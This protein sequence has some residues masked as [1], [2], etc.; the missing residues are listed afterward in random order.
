MT[1]RRV[2][3][4]DEDPKR[5]V[6]DARR[7]GELMHVYVH[8]SR[9]PAL[10]SNALMVDALA[11]MEAMEYDPDIDFVVV[12]GNMAMIAMLIANLMARDGTINM[13]LFDS[14]QEEYV[15]KTVQ[16]AVGMPTPQNGTGELPKHD[17]E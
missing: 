14:L 6:S 17:L 8:G 9:K 15:Q 10:W 7:F 5:D 2:F 13:L 12:T 3:V 4:M 1:Q 16:A 11:R